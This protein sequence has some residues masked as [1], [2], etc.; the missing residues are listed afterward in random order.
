MAIKLVL[1]NNF[2]DKHIKKNYYIESV[3]PPNLRGPRQLPNLPNG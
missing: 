2:A 3:G 1:F